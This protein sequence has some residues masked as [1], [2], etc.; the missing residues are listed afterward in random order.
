MKRERESEN[1]RGS[2][3]GYSNV[4]WGGAVLRGKSDLIDAIVEEGGKVKEK[5]MVLRNVENVPDLNSRSWWGGN[6]GQKYIEWKTTKRE[7]DT[8]WAGNWV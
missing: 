5:K 8:K 3:G 4:K 1:L 7:L 2:E 6:G